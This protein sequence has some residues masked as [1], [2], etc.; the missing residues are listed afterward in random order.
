MATAKTTQKVTKRDVEFPLGLHKATKQW[1]RK[2]A[3]KVYYFGTDKAA[4]AKRWNDE[5]DSIYAGTTPKSRSTGATITELANLFSADQKARHATTGKPGQ[6]HIDLCEATIKKLIGYVGSGCVVSDLSPDDFAKIKVRLFEPVKRTKPVR[7]KVY[8]RQVKRRSAET[9]AGDI[10]RIKVFLN[11]CHDSEHTPAPRFGNK[12]ATETEVAVTKQSI[13]KQAESRKDIQASDILA[14]IE[15]SSKHFKPVLWLGIN[16]GIGNADLSAIE[17][18]D[19]KN[20]D[21]QECWIDL[22]RLKTGAPRRFVLWPETKKAI[23]D[24]L[25]VR[26]KHTGSRFENVVFLTSHGIPWVRGVGENDRIDS[27]VTTFA[28]MRKAVGVSR[29]TFYDLRRTFATVGCETLDFAAVKLL[30]GHVKNKRD[31]TDRY[32]QHV[33]D[34]RIRRVCNH[35]RTWL[36]SGVTK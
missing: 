16:S 3:G 36:F 18:D 12:F 15:K 22:P 33:S 14:I 13:K 21:D 28:K 31:M 25:A 19:I 6:R 29:G 7:G 34:D 35:V 5:K 8:G 26:A 2:V 23:K 24:Y 11:W 20:L 1:C 27:I 9:V 17:W 10:R 30:M 32:A 4:A